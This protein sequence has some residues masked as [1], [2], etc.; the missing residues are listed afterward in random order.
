M[1]KRRFDYHQF[2]TSFKLYAFETITTVVIIVLL[3]D[4]AIKELHPAVERIW[5]FFHSP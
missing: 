2:L 1:S 5:Q 3:V 4:F